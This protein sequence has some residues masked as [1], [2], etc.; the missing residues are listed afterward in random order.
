MTDVFFHFWSHF[1]FADRWQFVLY[2]HTRP[3]LWIK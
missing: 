3:I 2:T 1:G